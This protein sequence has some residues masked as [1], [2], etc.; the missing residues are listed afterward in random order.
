MVLTRNKRVATPYYRRDRR[1]RWQPTRASR[2]AITVV[3]TAVCQARIPSPVLAGRKGP[4]SQPGPFRCLRMAQGKEIAPL[5]RVSP[6]LSPAVPVTFSALPRTSHGTN[7]CGGRKVAAGYPSLSR[8]AHNGKETD[9]GS[10]RAIALV[11]GVARGGIVPLIPRSGHQWP[12]H[13]TR[14]ETE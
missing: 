6:Y 14:T 10:L 7:S 1:L 4:T 9:E 12:G 3:G 2:V 5:I 11:E 8:T 13:K